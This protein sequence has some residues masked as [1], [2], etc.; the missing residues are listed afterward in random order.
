MHP[1]PVYQ[2]KLSGSYLDHSKGL[3]QL[4][5]KNEQSLQVSSGKGAKVT[6]NLWI[7]GRFVIEHKTFLQPGVSKIINLIPNHYTRITRFIGHYNL[8][9][10]FIERNPM[11]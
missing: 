9:L 6:L 1:V 10:A 5:L 2:Q 8:D 4:D 7:L 11:V 3:Q